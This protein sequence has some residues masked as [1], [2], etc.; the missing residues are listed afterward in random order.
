MDRADR[1]VT[2]LWL[3]A[4]GSRTPLEPILLEMLEPNHPNELLRE[5]TLEELHRPV[6]LL[7]VVLEC[8][9]MQPTGT[10]TKGDTPLHLVAPRLEHD[11][12]R[13]A[14][15]YPGGDC[16][17][18]LIVNTCDQ[19][20]VPLVHEVFSYLGEPQKE[21][22]RRQAALAVAGLS[23][24]DQ[25]HTL[26][27]AMPGY[28]AVLVGGRRQVQVLDPSVL[29]SPDGEIRV[30]LGS[31]S[32]TTRNIL[33]EG[34]QGEHVFILPGNLFEGK[35]NYGDIEFL[36]YLNFFAR[37][38]V[39]T[40]IVGTARQRE[41]LEQ[42][43]TLTIFGLFDPT[44]PEPKSFERLHRQYGVPD[45]ATYDFF[46]AAYETY[47]VR[48]GP[49]LSSPIVGIPDYVN[50]IV[51]EGEDTPVPVGN[52][53]EVWISP[54]G[55]G[56]EVR[57]VGAGGQVTTKRLEVSAPRRIGVVI[58]DDLR[59]SIQ[60]TTDRPRFG[61]TPLGT[62]H[63]FD[64][65][66]DLT[67]FVIW[68]NGRGILVDPSPEALSYLERIGVAPV[69][70]PYVFLTHV[71]ADHDGGLIEKLLSGSRT[72]VI[73]SEPVFRAFA[74]K[75]QLITGHDFEREGL[76]KHVAANPD[77]P[78]KIE[79]GGDVAELDSRW[80]LHPIPTNGFRITFGGKTFGYSGDTKY[81][82][83]LLESLRRTGGLSEDH[84]HDLLYFFWDTE[85]RPTVDLLYHEAG[86]PPIHTE[87]AKLQELTDE[88][89]ARTSLVHI[90]DSD[91]PEGFSPGK[92]QLFGTHVLLPNT[93]ESRRRIL[94]ETMR[95]VGYLY[96]IPVETLDELLANATI[97][98][99]RRGDVIIHKGPVDR[100]ERL[101]F[102]VV[103]DGEM[104]VKDGRRLVARL[105][106]ADSFG[107]WGIS[108]QRGFRIA[109]VVAARPSQCIRFSE[110]QY[111]WLVSRHPAIQGRISRMR[112]VLPRLQLAQERARLKVDPALSTSRSVIETMRSN[113]LVAFAIFSDVKSFREGEPVIVE[114]DEADGFY[115]LLSGHLTVSV[116]GRTVGE[117]SEGDVFGELGLL[118]GGKRGATITVVS[119]D[120]EVLFMSMRNFQELLHAVPAFAW[121]I[122]ETAGRRRV[123]RSS[124]LGT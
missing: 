98:D 79:I 95:L 53:G 109:D 43:L 64:P 59:E 111:R 66:G 32:Q 13:E 44:D 4:A 50:F 21:L 93:P 83:D 36:V 39:R 62:S 7:S 25:V 122:W 74:E 77:V 8:L 15:C 102:Y 97:L 87:K 117:L 76:V 103:A 40:R 29:F 94:L 78:V 116:Q 105:V 20:W 89:K 67:S 65:A 71:H 60:F 115:V 49:E 41:T 27:A 123:A 86:V 1:P 101:Y 45:R 34:L 70:I 55:R 12:W 9:G 69:D 18:G 81:D 80:N 51:L 124:A 110:G 99:C 46:Y 72:T 91:L 73:A 10:D 56:F 57:I 3:T 113:Q 11:P 35:T 5:A 88:V 24:E 90:A 120:A 16:P 19:G 48:T 28:D 107:E 37:E 52:A 106:K 33:R 112:S 92:P 119:A 30:Q 54:R 75:T 118:E 17:V 31:L 100:G 68:L 6:K 63:G 2:A 61:V 42:L 114:G 14:L 104:A 47:G 23:H 22:V 82:L 84:Y 121:G 58:P 26:R 38:R 85:G 108:H 96:D